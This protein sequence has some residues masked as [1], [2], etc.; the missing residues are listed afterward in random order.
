ML[1]CR[2]NQFS[3]ILISNIIFFPYVV[4]ARVQTYA[5]AIIPAVLFGLVVLISAGKTI[6]A[7]GQAAIDQEKINRLLEQVVKALDSGDNTAA[8]EFLNE[9][10]PELPMGAAKTHLD[11]AINGLHYSN[12]TETAK[13]H[14]QLGKSSLQNSTG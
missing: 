9:I 14:V 5:V 3:V 7:D 12:D 11:I 8:E 13:M 6:T 4:T 1:T 10:V 2:G